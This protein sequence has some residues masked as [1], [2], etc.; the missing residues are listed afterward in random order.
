M[1]DNIFSNNGTFDNL[2]YCDIDSPLVPEL[3]AAFGLPNVTCAN[4][5]AVQV[6]VGLQYWQSKNWDPAI[7]S[8]V[9]DQYC[10]NISSPDVQ[11]GNTN[12]TA[13][14]QQ[15][16]TAGGYSNETDELTTPLLNMMG[17]ISENQGGSCGASQDEC[18][19][20][21]N[22]TFYQQDDWDQSSWRSWPYMYCTQWG[23]LQTGSGV[24]ADQLPL[25]SRTIN[26]NF[27]TIICRDAFNIDTEPDTNAINQW[28]GY[29]IAY[30][31]LAII[32][33]EIDPWRPATPLAPE[34]QPWNRPNNTDQP[35]LLISGGVHH[36]DENGLFPNETTPTLPPEPVAQA[37]TDE[38]SFVGAWLKEAEP[39]FGRNF[40][41]VI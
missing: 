35:F 23:Y 27:S 9:F 18:Y 30:D 19:S 26:L 37:Q 13:M 16:L 14:A 20:S 25:L 12:Q 32:G 4:D 34:A 33:G 22:V 3:K 2:D 38:V 10:S 21:H 40:T 36:W 15:F 29:N 8:P 17:W 28:G 39:V 5:F 31:R 11:F 24:P 41:G 1:V 7:N 6:S